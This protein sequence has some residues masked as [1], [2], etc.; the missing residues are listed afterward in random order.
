MLLKTKQKS[1][2]L[3][4]YWQISSDKLARKFH[5]TK[6][7][8]FFSLDHEYIVHYIFNWLFKT[9]SMEWSTLFIFLAL[10]VWRMNSD[11]HKINLCLQDSTVCF[12]NIYQLDSN[13]STWCCMPFEQMGYDGLLNTFFT[14]MFLL[15][16]NWK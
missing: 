15:L 11:I 13:L 2:F 5:C 9:E 12:V 10:V 7:Y 4:K 3:H 6:N 16:G 8:T 1:V 14:T